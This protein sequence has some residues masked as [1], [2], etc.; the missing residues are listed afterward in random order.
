MSLQ[1]LPPQLVGRKS[2]RVTGGGASDED[3]KEI[4][5]V[6]HCVTTKEGARVDEE[7]VN[8]DITLDARREK[9][10]VDVVRDSF[11]ELGEGVSKGM[12]RR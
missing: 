3:L 11:A 1:D 9:V 4:L 12:T 2:A 8:I 6:K 10:R 5:L 7:N